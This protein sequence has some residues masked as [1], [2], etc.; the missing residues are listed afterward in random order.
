TVSDNGCGIPADVLSRV[1]Q[2]FFRADKARSRG[3]GH[4]GLGLA[5]VSRIAELHGARLEIDSEVGKGTTVQFVFPE[6]DV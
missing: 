4:A 3:Q 2:P 5:L 6:Q 1:T